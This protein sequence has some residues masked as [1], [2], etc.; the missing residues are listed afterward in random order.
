[1]SQATQHGVLLLLGNV[2]AFV[3][4]YF[5]LPIENFLFQVVLLL[6]EV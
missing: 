3:A 5:L 1:M 6:V 4:E 2:Y